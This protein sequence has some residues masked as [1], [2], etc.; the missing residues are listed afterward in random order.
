MLTDNG[1][2]TVSQSPRDDVEQDGVQ[3]RF[4]TIPISK[5]D[6][7]WY[8]RIKVAWNGQHQWCPKCHDAIKVKYIGGH[9]TNRIFGLECGHVLDVSPSY[10]HYP[11]LVWTQAKDAN[12]DTVSL[13]DIKDTKLFECWVYEVMDSYLPIVTPLPPAHDGIGHVDGVSDY[14]T[15]LNRT[16]L[17]HDQP[18]IGRVLARAPANWLSIHYDSF[19]FPITVNPYEFYDIDA[20]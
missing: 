11:E 10:R 1:Q 18:T 3:W 16:D 2:V 8:Y 17:Q 19:G 14:K 9:G 7:N 15:R 4:K 13:F 5:P 6:P 12:G 20:M